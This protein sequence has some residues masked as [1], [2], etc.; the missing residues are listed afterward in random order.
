MA[1]KPDDRYQSVVE[2]TQDIHR[3]SETGIIRQIYTD[4]ATIQHRQIA[5]PEI[6]VS[7]FFGHNVASA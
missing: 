2:F 6:P 4:F 5:A 7:Q 3:I 1:K